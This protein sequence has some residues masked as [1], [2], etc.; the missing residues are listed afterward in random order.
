M[1]RVLSAIFGVRN[2]ENVREESSTP[3]VNPPMVWLFLSGLCLSVSSVDVDSSE[4]FLSLLPVSP[5]FPLGF[6][7]MFAV[8][9]PLFRAE[10][11]Y[12]RAESGVFPGKSPRVCNIP[13][14]GCIFLFPGGYSRFYT[15]FGI[16]PG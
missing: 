4:R 6:G 12:F 9:S 11:C 3:P 7:E 2:V 13:V 5:W 10:R 8:F 14:P 1:R 16:F 15:L